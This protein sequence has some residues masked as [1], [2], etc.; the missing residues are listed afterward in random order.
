MVIQIHHILLMYIILKIVNGENVEILDVGPWNEDDNYWDTDR[1][2]FSG[3][4]LGVPEAQ[5]AYFD[6][7]NNGKINLEELFQIQQELIYLLN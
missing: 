3:L 6:R 4:G 2:M 1:R 5:A 7:Y